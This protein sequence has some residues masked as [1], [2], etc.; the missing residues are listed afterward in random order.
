MKKVIRIV[1]FYDDGTF[2]ESV[3]Y[4]GPVPINPLPMPFPYPPYE[5]TSN[6][7]KCGLKLDQVMGYACSNL[8]CPT[9]LGPIT[10]RA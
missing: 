3:P 2:S 6:C 4:V 8:N 1:T 7:Q 9:G 5:V 10:C